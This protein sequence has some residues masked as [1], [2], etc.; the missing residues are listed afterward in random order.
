VAGAAGRGCA[1]PA[2][3]HSRTGMARVGETLTGSGRRCK[4]TTRPA[5]SMRV[6]VAARRLV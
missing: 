4:R 1:A 2:G 5:R 6:V 3:D